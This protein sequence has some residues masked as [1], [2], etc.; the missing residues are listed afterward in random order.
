M[1]VT[2]NRFADVGGILW[3]SHSLLVA[4]GLMSME[5]G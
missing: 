1:Y 2:V 3:P 5:L 4:E